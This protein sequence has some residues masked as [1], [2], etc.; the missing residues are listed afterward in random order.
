[1]NKGSFLH[2]R[3]ND[4][5][6]MARISLQSLLNKRKQTAGLLAKLTRDMQLRV[7]V[8]D[9]QGK[10]LWGEPV[11]TT[12]NKF[13]IILQEE[14]LGWIYGG[15]E[16]ASVVDLLVHLLEKESEK[17]QMGSE[18]LDLYREINLI[19]N[20][21]E[22]LASA[23]DAEMIAQTA[24]G[25]VQQLID[26]S[27][28]AVIF[29]PEE[30]AE[31]Y[32]LASI[33]ET[34]F[35]KEDL[36]SAGPL[37]E[38]LLSGQANIYNGLS[39]AF[40]HN[41]KPVECLIFAP[42]KVKHRLLGM[43]LLVHEEAVEYNSSQLK[44]LT[45]LSLQS[46]SAIESAMLFQ[47]RIQEA[48]EK[49]E[50]MR[51]I[52]EVTQRFVPYEFISALGREK[53]TEVML[54]DQVQRDV[55]V[56][57]SDI[58]DYTTLAENMSPEDNFRFVSAFN[59]RV[60]PVI[61]ENKGFVNQ[62]LGDGIMALFP[63]NPFDALQAAIQM[64]RTVH[65]YNAERAAVNRSPIRVGM[66]LHT[67]PLIMGIIGD[68]QRM[69]AATI[70]DTVN[71]AARIES[72][73]KHFGVNILISGESLEKLEEKAKDLAEVPNFNLRYLGQVQVKGKKEPV[74]I[75][76]CFDG[77]MPEQFEKKK[78]TSQLFSR[79]MR[80]YYDRNFSAAQEAFRSVLAQNPDDLTAQLLLGRLEELL[81]AGVADD[82]TGIERMTSK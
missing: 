58:R 19:Y 34:Y 3:E 14:T 71:T 38:Y 13:P 2:Q 12:S 18:V 65:I 26:A 42:L 40:G 73:T 80:A 23:L 53:L 78:A 22:K 61:Y 75:Y 30:N 37:R 62:Y 45:T 29:Q 17:K 33:G 11:E 6:I 50:A 81:L 54:G 46:A 36:E 43:I 63:K 41:Q 24:L 64:Q 4:L 51:R 79:A 44:L 69:E 49:E 70:A 60:G 66:G 21:S 57:F 8:Q 52:H 15:E 28:G 77:D 31:A 48:E 82:W 35:G 39:T 74:A 55:T 67:G 9:I 68:V 5:R 20:F 16:A 59:S 10:W 76:E 25:E 47:K 32:I 7:S 1:M 72:L 27:G 56:F